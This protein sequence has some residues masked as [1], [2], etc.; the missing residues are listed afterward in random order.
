M[1]PTP[2]RTH[3][4]SHLLKKGE[5]IM[6]GAGLVLLNLAQIELRPLAN[7]AGILGGDDFFSGHAL[8][9]EDFDLQPTA[10]FGFLSPDSGHRRA[11]ISGDHRTC[12]V[13]IPNRFFKNSVPTYSVFLRKNQGRA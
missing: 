3:V 1:D 7:G 6:P 4:G 2:G 9:G 13:L 5:D 10:K 11:G 12:R 8:T